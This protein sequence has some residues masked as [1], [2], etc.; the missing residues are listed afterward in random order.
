MMH[1]MAIVEQRMGTSVDVHTPIDVF[2]RVVAH[3]AD[4]SDVAYSSAGR[5]DR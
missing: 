3:G 2:A 5:S 4:P 1:T